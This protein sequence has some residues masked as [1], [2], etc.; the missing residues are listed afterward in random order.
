MQ[1]KLEINGAYPFSTT[2]LKI[3]GAVI[4]HFTEKSIEELGSE[5]A[6]V[7][8]D[9]WVMPLCYHTYDSM[10][11]FCEYKIGGITIH[12]NVANLTYDIK[13]KYV[14]VF[15]VKGDGAYN[16]EIIKLVEDSMEPFLV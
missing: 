1:T 15:E 5:E 12:V 11:Y 6:I 9:D 2:F 4:H 3:K 13:D 8:L 14:M 7:G 16:Q 10:T